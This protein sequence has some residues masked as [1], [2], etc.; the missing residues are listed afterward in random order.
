MDGRTDVCLREGRHIKVLTGH[1]AHIPGCKPYE[2][3]YTFTLL[4]NPVSRAL[5]VYYYFC[6]Q[7]HGAGLFSAVDAESQKVTLEEFVDGKVAGGDAVSNFQVRHL[8]ALQVEGASEDPLEAAKATLRSYHLFGLQEQFDD[9]A[10]LLLRDLGLPDMASLP[11]EN[12]SA[13]YRGAE[14]I[15]ASTRELIERKNELDV[16]LWNWAREQLEVRRHAPP[17]RIVF[18]GSS[19]AIET[20]D[21]PQAQRVV[22]NTP[23]VHVVG[24]GVESVDGRQ[25]PFMCGETVRFRMV[26]LSEARDLQVTVGF[27]I[28]TMLRQEVFATNT[29][30]LDSRIRL[31][32]GTTSEIRFEFPALLAP[33]HYTIST[34]CHQGADTNS[35]EVY[36][37]REAV[38]EFDVVNNLLPAFGGLLFLPVAASHAD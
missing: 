9:F 12:V 20:H 27:G 15:P 16:A 21:Q 34:S 6:K 29:H 5:S 28:S 18:I 17:A 33:G 19:H 30:H 10:T 23:G 37:W 25:P 3:R 24:V 31:A 26:L 7:G 36:L 4:R 22:A 1:V 32:A 14:Q 11:R 38:A 2:S 35:G 13:A 8:A